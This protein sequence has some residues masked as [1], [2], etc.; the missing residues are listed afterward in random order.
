MV[1]F[2]WS[3]PTDKVLAFR[4]TSIVNNGKLDDIWEI[5]IDYQVMYE[6]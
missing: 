1:L 4:R 6:G 3:K 2:D 5:I